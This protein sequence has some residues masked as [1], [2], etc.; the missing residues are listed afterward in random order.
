VSSGL[1][2]I[3]KRLTIEREGDLRSIQT[4]TEDR[5]IPLLISR[6]HSRVGPVGEH[7]GTPVLVWRRRSGDDD[8][9]R[10]GEEDGIHSD[11][12]EHV[13]NRWL[14]VGGCLRLRMKLL[15]RVEPGADGPL[16]I[17]DGLYDTVRRR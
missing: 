16:Y 6:G 15:L 10:Q 11:L 9:G 12:V 4:G 2:G 13:V 3:D 17:L 1:R 8:Q 7:Q 14:I 5:G